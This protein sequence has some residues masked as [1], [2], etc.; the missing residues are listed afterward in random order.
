LLEG[1][2]LVLSAGADELYLLDEVSPADAPHL[3]AAFGD[4]AKLALLAN[5]P[6]WTAVLA[7]L[8]R[9]GALWRG[10]SPSPV[11]KVAASGPLAEPLSAMLAALA[12]AVI[13]VTSVDSPT[14]T[15]LVRTNGTLVDTALTAPTDGAHLLVDL[16]YHHTLSI[17]PLVWPGETACLQCLAGRIRQA[18]GDPVPPPAPEA[19]LALPLAAAYCAEVCR[20]FASDGGYAELVEQVLIV[21]L[22][23]L[24]SRR[25]RVHRLPWCPRCFPAGIP[26]GTGSFALPWAVDPAVIGRGVV[27]GGT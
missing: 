23:T 27:V 3:V 7:R 13:L 11:V 6:G 1:Q 17:G 24:E 2:D 18:W 5:E 15:L 9:I 19:T 16:A 14:L 12:P 22:R 8:E 25:E 20:H 26:A 21:D 10:G 4:Q